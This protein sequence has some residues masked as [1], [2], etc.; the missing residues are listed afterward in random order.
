MQNAHQKAGVLHGAMQVNQSFLNTSWQALQVLRRGKR[1]ADL[2]RSPP[3]GGFGQLDDQRL[4]LIGG[5]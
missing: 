4:M 2:P 1:R 5:F 3:F